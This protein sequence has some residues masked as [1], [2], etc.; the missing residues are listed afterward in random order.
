MVLLE[1]RLKRLNLRLSKRR[2]CS[3]EH[4]PEGATAHPQESDGKASFCRGPVTFE[5]YR[6]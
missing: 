3:H 6:S 4:Q 1:G 5:I 2:R